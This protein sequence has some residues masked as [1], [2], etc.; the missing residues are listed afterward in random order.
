MVLGADINFLSAF[1]VEDPVF[2][3]PLTF[4]KPRSNFEMEVRVDP[5]GVDPDGGTCTIQVV[6]VSPILR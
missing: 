4:L 3:P 2:Y 6:I 1:P 5:D